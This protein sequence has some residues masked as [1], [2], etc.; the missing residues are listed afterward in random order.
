MRVKA[1]ASN[2]TVRE[3]IG[4][5]AD[6]GP[7]KSVNE[8]LSVIIRKVLEVDHWFGVE[9]FGVDKRSGGAIVG[10]DLEDQIQRERK[11]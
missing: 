8:R 6:S 10:R 7:A 1:S 2:G 5:R 4:W 11:F 9:T 3:L